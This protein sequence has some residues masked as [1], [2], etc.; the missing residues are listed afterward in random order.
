MKK[1]NNPNDEVCV[2][3]ERL[4]MLMRKNKVKQTTLGKHLNVSRQ[5]VSTYVDGSVFPNMKNL[6][7]I[8]QFFGVSSDYMLGLSVIPNVVDERY[9]EE[10]EGIIHKTKKYE[11]EKTKGE[12]HLIKCFNKM[13][14]NIR[15]FPKEIF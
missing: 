11:E 4:S 3:A 2:F 6:L 8:C 9:F 14:L 13:I 12:N 1:T 10:L 15:V 5:A 7:K